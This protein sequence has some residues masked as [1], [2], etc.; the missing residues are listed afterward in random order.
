MRK[1]ATHY[2][3]WNK[4]EEEPRFLLS[5]WNYPIH[6]LPSS[7]FLFTWK[8]VNLSIWRRGDMTIWISCAPVHTSRCI[9]QDDTG[10]FWSYQIIGQFTSAKKTDQS[11]KWTKQICCV[12]TALGSYT[13]F[14]FS[15]WQWRMALVVES[16]SGE[17]Y[18]AFQDGS[19]GEKVQQRALWN[20]RWLHVSSILQFWQPCKLSLFL[21]MRLSF[22]LGFQE[23]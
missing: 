8:K 23:V 11:K 4:S 21:I 13:P 5:P 1:Q 17:F 9:S 19:V 18:L 20:H 6:P 3:W 12:G 15:L 14:Y 16:A 2:G 7:R 10:W 22:R